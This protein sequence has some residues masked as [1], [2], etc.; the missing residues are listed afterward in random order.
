MSNLLRCTTLLI[1]L[2]AIIAYSLKEVIPTYYIDPYI[3]NFTDTRLLK[4]VATKL[5]KHSHNEL[6]HAELKYLYESSSSEYFRSHEL[7]AYDYFISNVDN[8]HRRGS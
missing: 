2:A 5:S 4:C 1:N 6:V 3:Q 8:P 7:I